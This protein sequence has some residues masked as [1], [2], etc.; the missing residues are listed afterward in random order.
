VV[1]KRRCQHGVVADVAAHENGAVAELGGDA[2][3][4][5]VERR[6]IEGNDAV[7]ILHQ[8]ADDVE[9]DEAGAACHRDRSPT[10]RAH[11][12]RSFL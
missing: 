5:R 4:R 11:P 1:G 3:S 7:A 10:T 6:V 9:S 12:T 8:V 2:L